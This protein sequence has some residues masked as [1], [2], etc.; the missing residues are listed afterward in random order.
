MLVVCASTQ[1][2]EQVVGSCVGSGDSSQCCACFVVV[3]NHDLSQSSVVAL[4]VAKSFCSCIVVA[5]LEVE[6]THSLINF[7]YI[8]GFAECGSGIIIL[9]IQHFD[10]TLVHDYFVGSGSDFGSF[11]EEIRSCFISAGFVIHHT[12]VVVAAIVFGIDFG[13]LLVYSCFL[14]CIFG[15]SCSIKQFID[16]ER[17][18]I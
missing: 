16:R 13:Y 17:C 6:Y 7:R 3:F 5:F 4:R 2:S 18:G 15:D 9:A 11:I 12:Q 10:K 1:Y 14:I 8:T